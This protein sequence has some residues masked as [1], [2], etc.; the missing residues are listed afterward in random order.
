MF[1][2]GI[3]NIM[4]RILLSVVLL[5]MII[6]PVFG[7][8][9]I[10]GN[11]MTIR[12]QF[13]EGDEKA[14]EITFGE[15]V[16]MLQE[17][18]FPSERYVANYKIDLWVYAALYQLDLPF[19]VSTVRHQRGVYESTITK[20]GEYQNGE[21]GLWVYYVNGIRSPRAIALCCE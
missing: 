1:H 5:T 11:R 2:G 12:I 8:Y 10:A 4:R 21:N 17:S 18:P 16:L 13:P 7:E 15:L 9:H 3:Q 19:E 6:L 20:I 14:T